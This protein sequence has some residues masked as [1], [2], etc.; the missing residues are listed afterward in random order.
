MF[1]HVVRG[2][3]VAAISGY[4]KFI[5]PHK[6]FACAHRILYGS[7]SCSQYFKRVIAEEG[8]SVAISKAKGRFQECRD[9]NEILKERKSKCRAKNKYDATRDEQKSNFGIA[10][11]EA[12][13]SE[14]VEPS[15]E[16]R[17]LGGSQWSSKR[18]S[19]PIQNNQNNNCNNCDVPDCYDCVHCA[20]ALNILPDECSDNLNCDHPLESLD[21]ADFNCGDFNCGDADCLSGT[22]CSGLDCGGC[23]W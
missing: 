17:K 2:T 3:A 23:G 7:D 15:S 4:Q 12:E 20:D 19:Q 16:P 10:A 8:I 13:D 5:S 18:R 22:D 21:C 9:A 14:K 6:G 1:G 11:M